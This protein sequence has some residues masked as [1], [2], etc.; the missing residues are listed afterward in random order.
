MYPPGDPLSREH[1]QRRSLVVEAAVALTAVPVIASLTSF[2]GRRYS[3]LMDSCLL[4]AHHA[5]FALLPKLDDAAL[6][7]ERAMLLSAFRQF[8]E[9][10]GEPADRFAL[11]ALY[12]DATDE[13]QK[14]SGARRAAL[15]AT[16]ADAHDFMT[17]LQSCWSGLVERSMLDEALE[18]LL[19]NYPRVSRRD[20][21][22]V[23]QLIRQTFRHGRA[24]ANGQSGPR[25]RT[26][27]RRR[28]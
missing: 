24:A 9:S 10:S 28:S 8:A 5:Y 21:D 17:V 14:A 6:Q 13:P 16:P 11:L 1:R 12:F 25:D 22:E 27:K 19:D 2:S 18:V 20:L 4:L 7:P 26:A 3:L 15:A 23:G